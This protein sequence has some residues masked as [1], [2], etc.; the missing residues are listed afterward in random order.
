M[1]KRSVIYVFV[2]LL[3]LAALSAVGLAAAQDDSDASPYLGILVAEAPDGGVLVREV[4][5]DSP[6][7][8]AGIQQGDI[9]KAINDQAVSPDTIRDVLAAFAV[10]DTVTLSVERDGET[11]ALEATLA[12]R[13][14]ESVMPPSNSFHM[15]EAVLFGL[16]LEATDDGLVVREVAAGSPAEEAGLQ[17]GDIITR[18]GDTEVTELR[19]IVEAMRALRD[20]EMLAVEVNRDGETITLEVEPGQ[21][22]FLGRMPNLETPFNFNMMPGGARLGV[23]FIMLDEATAEER[24]LDLTEGALITEVV[25]DSPA[26]AAGLLV[27]DIIIAVSGD[28]VDAE[29][30]L[31]DRLLAYE[32]DDTVTLSVQRGGE[33]LQ[34]NATLDE[35]GLN[36]VMPGGFHFFGPDGFDFNFGDGESGFFFGPR[37]FRFPNIPQ[38]P[39]V[40]PAQPNV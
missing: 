23:A 36:A 13:P 29:R 19:D 30:T 14:E 40:E 20:S 9:L 10:G 22:G 1:H 15:Q 27:D 12:A 32:P 7:E 5:P 38:S 18:I 6:G 2:A 11:L 4:A 28:I 31:R 24:N 3:A 16:A 35:M 33:L 26:Q 39:S 34:L 21:F 37:G 25:E 8:E 17:V